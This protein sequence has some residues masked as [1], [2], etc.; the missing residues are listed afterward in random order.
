VFPGSLC[1]AALHDERKQ[2][3][4]IFITASPTCREWPMSERVNQF[5]E[6]VMNHFK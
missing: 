6:E 1:C 4:L 3:E 5:V 2:P